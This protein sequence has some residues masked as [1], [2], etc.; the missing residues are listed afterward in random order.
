MARTS[1]PPPDIVAADEETSSSYGLGFRSIRG[2]FIFKR[3][4][5]P[6]SQQNKDQNKNADRQWRN[7]RSQQGR[8]RRASPYVYV[9]II[10][11]VFIY[12]LAS[13]LLQ[14]SITSVFI[15]SE[16]GKSIR[17]GL[18]FGSSLKFVPYGLLQRFS[19]RRGLDQLRTEAR[20]ANRAPR[21]A[22]ILGNMKK[23]PRTLLLYTVMK[24]A[25]E[26]G[27][28][29]KIYA[30]E[31]GKARSIWERIGGRVSVL[32]PDRFGHIDWLIFQGI[33]V[34]SL[35]AKDGTSSLMQ[36]PFCSVPL[37]W[38]IQEDILANRLP[39]YEES[40]WEHLISHW[41]YT[42]SRADVVV[43][44]DY[45]LP[46]LYSVLDS[47]NFFVIPGSPIDV[48]AAELYSRTHSKYQLR[49]D[50]GFHSDELLILIFGSSFFY[51]GVAWDYAM[52]MHTIGPLLTKYAKRRSA[53]G[54]YKFLFLCGNSTDEY[55]EA[56]Q[57][58]AARLGLQPGSVRHYGMNGDTSSVLFM[59]DI[60]VYGSSQ[61]EQAFPP[62]LVRAMSFGIPVIA[63]SLPIIEKYVVD[64][65]HTV[66][67]AKHNPDALLQ[68]FS[69]LVSNGKLTNF[70]HSVASSGKRRAKNMLALDCITGYIKLLENVI[71]F[72]SDSLLPEPISKIQKGEWEWNLFIKEI[73]QRSDYTSTKEASFL[74][75]IE[76]DQENL[77]DSTN[78]FENRTDN[79]VE[80]IPSELDWD[81]LTEMERA[82]DYERQEMEELDERTERDAGAWDYIYRNARK[83][84]KLRFETNERDEGELERT[85]QPLCIYEVYN[86]AG[87]WPFL[88]H[89]SLYRGLSLSKRSR[90]TRSDD[91][92]AVSRLPL[93]ND[94]YYRN[95]LCDTGGM[96]SIANRVDNIHK[97]PWIGFQSWRSVGRKVSLSVDA[98]KVLEETIQDHTKGDVVFFWVRLEV[99]GRNTGGND[100]LTFWSMCDIFNGGHCRTAFEDAFRHMYGLP[101]HIEA[102]PPMPYDDGHWSA[103]HSWVMPTSS[104][105]QFV[106]FSRMFVDSL[107]SLQTNYSNSTTCLL[108]SSE[109]E[110]KH[111]YCQILELLV[112]VWA[113][114][115]A[116][117]MVYIDPQTGSFEEQH[118]VEQRKGF[119]W[120]KYFNATLLKT[121]DE[122]L[123]E[124][125]DDGDYPRNS[126]L[127][128]LTG[129]VHWQG[130]YEREREERYRLKM[131]KK[132]KTKEKL[133]ERMKHGYKQKSLGG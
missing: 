43:F 47:G 121:M 44:P 12:A 66:T 3:N 101:A 48:W 88:H 30:I 54:S 130:I 42:F 55:S 49:E 4:Q 107:D 133:L 5:Q 24:N 95:I 79:L 40:S 36:E 74:Y 57:E 20:L 16:S 25:R 126:W 70:A 84:E 46:M 21:L 77:A 104:F 100:G 8:V 17:H 86:G 34:D 33:V 19:Q 37:I 106:M 38:M 82:E 124:V 76:Q 94:T 110:R 91:V 51:S 122:D 97:R 103:L 6:Q 59:A 14:S 1:S 123:A 10:I 60:V 131:E 39:V 116:R 81:V 68:A 64:G 118:P 69:L 29:L 105:L 26:L 62:L 85:G 15:Q 111:C 11:V 127:W 53:E 109:L 72:P 67:L 73:E 28:F 32:S 119:M 13:L 78:I 108:G 113:Y 128:P 56:L 87:A 23:D 61:D 112:N 22:L 65:V 98:E 63:P 96:F 9:L 102:L 2:R 31:D 52:A 115:S 92:D 35:A 41:K 125:A 120:A 27:Y 83:S 114:H 75:A 132:R 89:G 18:K 45:S 71:N 80:D 58:V 7:N 50:N 93:L 129:E 99:D 117:K 90:R